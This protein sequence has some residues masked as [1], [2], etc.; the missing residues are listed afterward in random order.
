MKI[1]KKIK[2]GLKGIKKVL[3][4]SFLITF[5]RFAAIPFFPAVAPFALYLLMAAI[6]VALTIYT[7]QTGENH[8]KPSINYP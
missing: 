7:F 4:N 5:A 3:V 8:I 6:L 2:S 1:F